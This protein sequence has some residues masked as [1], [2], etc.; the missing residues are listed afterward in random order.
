MELILLPTLCGFEIPRSYV[1]S[2]LTLFLHFSQLLALCF[3]MNDTPS[4]PEAQMLDFV[5]LCLANVNL[6]RT[7]V[8]SFP[9]ME[10]IVVS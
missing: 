5:F 3:V 4:T 6:N 10:V 9:T 1:T 8:V 2:F 7:F